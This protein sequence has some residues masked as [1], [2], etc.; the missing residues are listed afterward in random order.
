MLVGIGP[1]NTVVNMGTQFSKVTIRT[2]ENGGGGSG[3]NF[4]SLQDIPQYMSSRKHVYHSGIWSGHE[5]MSY[6]FLEGQHC[7]PRR[8]LRRKRRSKS[9]VSS[10]SDF[11]STLRS[12]GSKRHYP[13]L[14]K[15]PGSNSN[16]SESS[17]VNEFEI[18]SGISV[19]LHYEPTTLP[20]YASNQKILEERRDLVDHPR[21]IKRDLSQHFEEEKQHLESSL[22]LASGGGTSV[23]NS[24]SSLT[25]DS[26]ATTTT[27]T[28]TTTTT[29]TI[30]QPPKPPRARSP[31]LEAEPKSITQLLKAFYREYYSEW[32]EPGSAVG[33]NR[34]RSSRRKKLHQ[35]L[36]LS[37]M[38]TQVAT[39]LDMDDR[40]KM[41]QFFRRPRDRNQIESIKIEDMFHSCWAIPKELPSL[42]TVITVQA[43]AG[44]GKSSMLKYMCMKWGCD[45][46]WKAYFDYLVFVECRTL[47][48]HGDMPASGFILLALEHF[49][50]YSGTSGSAILED[51]TT[52]AGAGRVLF[53]L[54]GL[55]EVHGVGQLDNL[56]QRALQQ[57]TAKYW[58]SQD[59]SVTPLEFCQGILTG[60]ILTGCHIIVT[61]RPH[62]LSHLHAS[63]WFLSLPKRIVSLD[64]QGLSEEGIR[65]F[66]HSFMDSRQPMISNGD[67]SSHHDPLSEREG[68]CPEDC[69]CHALQQRARCDPYIFSLATNPFYLWLI[70]TIFSE[71]GEEF[72]PKT[73]TQLYTWVM[74]VFAQRWQ[75]TSFQISTNLENS[76]VTFLRSFAQLCYHLVRSGNI[77]MSAVMDQ[78][79]NSLVFPEF[80][81]V[82]IDREK[83][84]SFGLMILIEE[85][86]QLECEFRHLS[87]AEYL[88][89]LHIYCT[90]EQTLKGF[91]RDRK[92]LILQYLSGLSS[93]SPTIDQKIVRDFLQEIE[94]KSGS[95][96][97]SVSYLKNIQ[98]M[99]GEWYNQQGLQKQMLFMRCVF[100]A[101]L[102]NLT[103][104]PFPGLKVINIRGSALL[105]LDLIIIGNFVS[106]LAD[107]HRLLELSLRDYPLDSTGLEGLMQC[108]TQ[109]RTVTLC[110][111]KLVSP[112]NYILMADAVERNPRSRLRELRLIDVPPA[113][114][115][116]DEPDE[117]GSALN[118]LKSIGSIYNVRVSI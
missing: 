8:S 22:V 105:S 55:D 24:S 116:E 3:K 9:L 113:N 96:V 32:F 102:Q 70:C 86:D 82:S 72:I 79:N 100:E 59:A 50:E 6:V 16:Y 57:K 95:H 111:K 97:S 112:A 77:R 66:I 12:H 93:Q 36:V 88:S 42:S 99:Q 28:T 114:C 5:M 75:N 87:L 73:L 39:K 15:I 56:K 11:R 108:L 47:N 89:A 85:G 104:Y 83:A 115:D 48:R 103:L 27:A 62:T 80:N 21:H 41:L 14:T 74:I 20:L 4:S 34:H 107:Q 76:T 46:L 18:D 2:H 37:Q 92:E 43:P 101:R 26:I 69:A 91:P 81:G 106:S 71:A 94:G 38:N 67:S 98:K 52:K 7:E 30:I 33:R 53:L 25:A 84:E 90:E 17:S 68:L 110:A 31:P 58:E 54:D 117:L 13:R 44:I 29:A 60:Q 109:I 78:E 19:N 40:A 49:K 35:K 23:A 10:V 51:V 63:K 64:I 1:G 118:H 61:S 65:S 45:E